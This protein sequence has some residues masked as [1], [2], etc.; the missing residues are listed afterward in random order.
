MTLDP[1]A[2]AGLV[3]AV[4]S[5]WLAIVALQRGNKN[6]SAALVVTIHENFRQAWQRVRT[7]PDMTTRSIEL[8]ELLNLIETTCAIQQERSVTGV[9]RELIETY[10]CE[11]LAIIGRDVPARQ[12]IARMRTAPDTFK[13]LRRF[14]AEMRRSGQALP[15]EKVALGE[16]APEAVPPSPLPAPSPQPSTAPAMPASARSVRSKAKAGSKTTSKP[17]P[18]SALKSAKPKAKRK[19]KAA[20]KP[21]AK[22]PTP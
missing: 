22:L 1:V 20:A 19:P 6:A 5:F 12:A 14:F 18:Q 11:I 3:I 16:V 15:L 8:H 10:L 7:A 9:S 13:Y 2:V 17:A 4:A 21:R